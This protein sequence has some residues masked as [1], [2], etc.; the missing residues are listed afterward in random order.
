ME[1]VFVEQDERNAL[2]VLSGAS[3][4]FANTL[5]RTMIGEV[6]TLAIE[7]VHIYDN[8]SVLFDEMIAHRLGLI[9]LKTDL[10]SYVSQSEC[11]CEGAGCPACTVTYTLSAEGPGIVRS[12][13]LIP[14]DPRAAPAEANVPIV[15][16]DEGQKLVLEARAVVNVGREHAK[17][18]PTVACGYKMY[19]II[20][21]DERCDAC[22]MC[23]EECPRG[24]LRIGS[25]RKVEVGNPQECSLCRLCEQICLSGAIGDEPAIHVSADE[26]RYIFIV[27][28]DG[29]IPV[30]EILR[31]ALM[32][33]RDK[34]NATGTVL[35]EV[36]G[37]TQN[38]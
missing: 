32:H 28:S 34:A 6:P 29:S 18:Q 30:R 12:R 13:D 33:T 19:P 17:W 15:E 37:G 1:I 3:P 23:V 20:R 11:A 8:T 14:A 10:S 26:T 24:V 25:S 38:E 35:Q 7:D 31:R 27:E 2:F 9:P 4:P 22:G 21:I 5:R 36:Y 16:L